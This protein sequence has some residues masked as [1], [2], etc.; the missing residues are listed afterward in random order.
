MSK[1][2]FPLRI[3]E[4]EGDR[5]RCHPPANRS[6]LTLSRPRGRL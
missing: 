4:S 3:Q 6:V 2:A 1:T 5:G